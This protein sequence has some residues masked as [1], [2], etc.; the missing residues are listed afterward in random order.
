MQVMREHLLKAFNALD[1][2]TAKALLASM[3]AV[4]SVEEVCAELITPTLWD[5]GRL[6]EEGKLSVSVEHSCQQHLSAAF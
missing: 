3:L 5:I 2:T 4:Y 1:E 6:W